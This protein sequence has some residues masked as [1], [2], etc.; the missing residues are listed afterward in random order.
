MRRGLMIYHPGSASH[1]SYIR[2]GVEKQGSFC[3]IY[4]Q[5]QWVERVT[6]PALRATPP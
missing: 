5:P 2:R 4:L 1:P 6:T 3:E